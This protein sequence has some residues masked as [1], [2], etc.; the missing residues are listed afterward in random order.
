MSLDKQM[1]VYQSS[2]FARKVKR[3]KPAEKAELDQVVRDIIDSPAVGDE[4]KG[5]LKGVFIYKFK[6]H[7]NDYLLA[8]RICSENCLELIMVGPHENYYRA[9]KN[10]LKS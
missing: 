3:L 8:Y 9:L 5:D 10:Y 7:K 2:F 1:K 6:L 4:K